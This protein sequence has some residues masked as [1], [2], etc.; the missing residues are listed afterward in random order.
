MIFRAKTQ[1]GHEFVGEITL[2]DEITPTTIRTITKCLAEDAENFERHLEVK[3]ERT[4][5]APVFPD[6]KLTGRY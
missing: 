2:S 5:R 1:V 6:E 3:A 4:Y